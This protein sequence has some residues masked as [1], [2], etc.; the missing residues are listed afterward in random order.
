MSPLVKA[1]RYM[2]LIIS[3]AEWRRQHQEDS[4]VDL[5]TKLLTPPFKSVVAHRDKY[6]ED[7]HM[8]CM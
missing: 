6:E 3:E 4:S 1:K 5:A 8:V 2:S 7:T